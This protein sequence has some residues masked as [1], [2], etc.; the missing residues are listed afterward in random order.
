MLRR[1]WLLRLSWTLLLRSGFLWLAVIR[2]I[3]PILWRVFVA[4]ITIAVAIAVVAV[5]IAVEFFVFLRFGFLFAAGRCA[6]E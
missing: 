2:S 4:V 1:T 3:L 5:A 6:T